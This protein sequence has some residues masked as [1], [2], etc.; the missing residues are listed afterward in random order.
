ME[1]V[2]IKNSNGQSELHVNAADWG[3]KGDGTGNWGY[4]PEPSR[5]SVSVQIVYEDGTT[6]PLDTTANALKNKTFVYGYWSS[7][8]GLGTM[9]FNGQQNYQIYKVTAETGDMTSSTSGNYVTVTDFTWDSNE[10]TVWEGNATQSVSIGNPARNPSYEAPYDNLTWNIT[11]YN[12]NNAILIRVYVRTVATKSAL[13]VHYVDQTANTEFYNYNIAV[14][15]GTTFDTGFDRGSEKNTLVNNTVVNYNG[16]SQT[17]T[18]NLSEMPEIGAQYRYSDY[19]CVKVVRSENGKDVY[20]YYNFSNTHNFVIDFG[21]PLKITTTDLGIS[22]DWTSASVT[23]ARYGTAAATVG[24]GIT[25]TPTEV[26]KGVETLQLTL[27][28]DTDSVMHQIYIYPAS[29]VLYE[30][31]FLTTTAE[32]GR[33]QWRGTIGKGTGPQVLGTTASDPHVYGYDPAYQNSNS[34]SNGTAWTVSGLSSENQS[35]NALTTTFKGN[36]FDLIGSCGPDTGLVY[37]VLKDS[38]NTA[39]KGAVIDTSFNDPA[40]STISQ[41][42]LAHLML[43]TED[44]YTA[45]IR[46]YFRKG[47]TAESGTSAAS[48]FSAR[49]SAVD[50]SVLDAVLEDIYEDDVDDLDMI[51]FDSDSV[52]SSYSGATMY[53]LDNGDANTKTAAVQKKDGTTVT[54][55]GFRVYKGTNEAY[56]SSEQGVTYTNVLDAVNRDTFA[57]YIEGNATGEYQKTQYESKGG[58]QNEIYLAKDQAVAFAVTGQTPIQISARAVNGNKTATMV[59]NS[60]TTGKD[61]TSNTEMYYKVTLD[62]TGVVTIKNTGEGL[63]ALGNLKMQ[64]TKTT[65][66][67][68]TD[69]DLQ[70]AYAMLRT[71]SVDPEPEPEPEVFT[72]DKFDIKVNS[73]KVIRNKVVTLTVTASTDVEYLMVNGKKVK[74]SNGLLVKWGISKNYVFVVSD[75]V[76]RDSVQNYTI[77]AYNADGLASAEYTAEG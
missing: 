36:G 34:N 46:G 11:G 5:C 33:A 65:L 48:T 53:T 58:P 13:T 76:K 29:N 61:L 56:I 54:I 49:A 37:V 7:G 68:M 19:T 38:S 67:A 52:L 41:V 8:R 51:Y 44:T 75:I 30:D 27:T 25:Y 32:T 22:G 77:Q 50:A 24:E 31:G 42:P 60:A 71:M 59:V 45:T 62:E 40:V 15:E 28:G 69:S 18:A 63:L 3:T 70:V 6:N 20:L 26:L 23:G 64:E 4:T 55:D 17:V 66:R 16:V 35:T 14:E 2:G 74:P 1:V 72:P 43:D 12:K 73:T 57:A 47:T 10:E 21:L 9:I 39:V